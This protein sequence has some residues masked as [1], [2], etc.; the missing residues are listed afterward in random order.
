MSHKKHNLK[1]NKVTKKSKIFDL[2]KRDYFN[3]D[4]VYFPFLDGDVPRR[5]SYR[6]CISQL[7]K[8][9]R[10]FSHVYDVHAR[11]TCLTANFFKQGYRYHKLRT[12]FSKFYHRHHEFSGF[13]I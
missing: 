8:F 2:Y 9:A 4:I 1:N 6:V 7:T 11:N 10:V 3:F 5:P 12:A 13:K